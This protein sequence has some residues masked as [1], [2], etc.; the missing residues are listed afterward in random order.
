VS[1]IGISDLPVEPSDCDIRLRTEGTH[2]RRPSRI[3][4]AFLSAGLLFTAGLAFAQTSGSVDLSWSTV[5]SGGN[6]STAGSI[7]VSGSIGQ[8][9][10]ATGK[11]TGGE[12]SLTGGFW[13]GVSPADSAC[14]GDTNDDDRV[15]LNDLLTVLGNF[16]AA[17]AGGPADGD[18]DGSGT[19][20][21]NDLLQ[22][23]AN[24][25]NTC[26]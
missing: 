25:G 4:I 19:V 12:I 16:G 3:R 23:L 8:G 14:P 9:Q 20:D 5:S 11:L 2:M 24:F 17:V 22:V 1:E 6:E 21:L 18:L 10:T 15:D 7:S 13:Y 26:P